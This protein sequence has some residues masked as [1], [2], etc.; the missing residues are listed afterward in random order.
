MFSKFFFPKSKY[1]N[2]PE[3]TPIM[4]VAEVVSVV[5]KNEAGRIRVKIKGVDDKK[6]SK[7]KK[8]VEEDVL[9]EAFPLLPK[10]IHI[11]PKK[12]ES[13]FVINQFLNETTH[14]YWIGPIIS[15]PHKIKEDK[16]FGTAQS[17]LVEGSNIELDVAPSTLPGAE[18]LYPKATD[19]VIQ[20]RDN[21]DILLKSSEILLRTGKH[22]RDNKLIFNKIDPGFIQIKSNTFLT[23]Y[24]KT[25]RNTKDKPNLIGSV[26]NV[27]GNRINLLS[28]D[29]SPKFNLTDN[30]SQITDDEIIKIIKNAHPLAFGDIL[31]DV[32]TVFRKF[33]FGHIHPHINLP[34][35]SS[36][37]SYIGLHGLE[38][39]K[40]LSKNI[41][42]N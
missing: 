37:E 15:Q 35:D 34:A 25:D 24:D 10:L 31:V 39:T 11:L 23:N 2:E 6:G 17:A 26:V 1:L 16:Y 4:Y 20:G 33:A 7:G 14:R 32:L 30:L 8:E 12:G 29:G 21:A 36:E 28:H 19:Y 38:L 27:V 13:V 42:I 40:I 3:R 5:D 22:D 41:R 18:G 9:L